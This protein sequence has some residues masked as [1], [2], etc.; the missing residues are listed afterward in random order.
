MALLRYLKATGQIVGVYDATLPEML[1]AQC[2]G[3][4]EAWGF[5]PLTEPFPVHEQE[6]WEVWQGQVRARECVVLQ[7]TPPTVVADGETICTITRTPPIACTLWVAHQA[8][9]VAETDASVTLTVDTPG[10]LLVRLVPQEGY[11]AEPLSIEA[12]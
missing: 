10:R 4:D 8:V 11:W 3:Q 7:A 12:V 1:A 9:F 6:R 5:L 2:E